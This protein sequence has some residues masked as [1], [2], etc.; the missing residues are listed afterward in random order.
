MNA[1]IS[2]TTSIKLTSEDI[3]QVTIVKLDG[4]VDLYSSKDLEDYLVSLIEDNK[5]NILI[6]CSSLEYI[7]SAGFRVLINQY[8]SID[9]QQGFLKFC[10]LNNSVESVFKIVG[11]YDF[12][13]V[14]E[15]MKSALH[16]YW[17]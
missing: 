2:M 6:D 15:D 8:K 1:I 14:F 5:K 3:G 9:S 11:L 16:S 10:Y 7:T 4:F 12:F 17:A 13:E